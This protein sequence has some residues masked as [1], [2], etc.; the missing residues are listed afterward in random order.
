L[1]LFLNY[2]NLEKDV[3]E[4]K[5]ENEQLREFARKCKKKADAYDYLTKPF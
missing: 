3:K 4:L 2:D 1:K 5:Q